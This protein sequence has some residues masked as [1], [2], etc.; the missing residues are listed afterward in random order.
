MLKTDYR[1]INSK[2]LRLPRILI[3]LQQP[4]TFIF[5]A[6]NTACYISHAHLSTVECL[7]FSRNVQ[8]YF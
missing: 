7:I 5:D 3:F 1:V 2:I 4:L 8:V 6:R